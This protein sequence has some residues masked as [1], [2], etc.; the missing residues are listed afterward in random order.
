MYNDRERDKVAIPLGVRTMIFHAEV[1]GILM[2][3]RVYGR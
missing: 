2:A 1:L 3:A